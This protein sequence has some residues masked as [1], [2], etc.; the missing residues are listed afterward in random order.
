MLQGKELIDLSGAL[1]GIVDDV[2]TESGKHREMI[3]VR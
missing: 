1:V 2:V 3:I